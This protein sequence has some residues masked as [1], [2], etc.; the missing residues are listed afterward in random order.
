MEKIKL[1]VGDWSDDGHGKT[2]IYLIKSNLSKKDIEEA[3]D[4]G[5]AKIGCDITDHC[6]GYT[7]SKIAREEYNKFVAQGFKRGD[8]IYEDEDDES[9]PFYVSSETYRDLYLFT[10]KCGNDNF[11]FK[12]VFEDRKNDI[13]IGGYGLFS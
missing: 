13:K 7:D 8:Y 11:I 2:D 1:I 3:F 9:G 12:H 4:Q 10:V 6:K 5:V